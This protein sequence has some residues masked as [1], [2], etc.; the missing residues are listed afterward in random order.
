MRIR[1]ALGGLAL[2]GLGVLCATSAILPR[3]AFALDAKTLDK[4]ATPLEAFRFG[5]NAYKQGDKTVAVEALTYAAEKGHAGAQWKLGRMYAEGDGLAKDDVKA[6][7]MFSEVADAHADD[8]PNGSSARFVSNAFVALGLYYRDGI[9]NSTVKPDFNRSRQMFAYAASY[10]GDS[11]AQLNL[12]RMYYEG[13]GGERDP[14]QAVRWAKLAA[15]KGNV[16]AQALLGHML[17]EGEGVSREPVLGLMFLTVAR[18]RSDADDPWIQDM[19]EQAFSL[20]TETE[21]RTA[22]A[23]ADDWLNKNGK[24]NP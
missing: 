4:N 17:F 2:F 23:L 1:D 9:P 7:E 12:A 3:V 10:F 18:D 16:G 14:K 20:A 11:D 13:Q 15:N 24:P 5:F 22:L 19:Q 21:R 6:F 8:N